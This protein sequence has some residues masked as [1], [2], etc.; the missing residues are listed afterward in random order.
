M[1]TRPRQGW[2]TDKDKWWSSTGII[3]ALDTQRRSPNHGG[4]CE[5]TGNDMSEQKA[6]RSGPKLQQMNE[7]AQDVGL[8]ANYDGD[9]K[10]G[11]TP[12]RPATLQ[13]NTLKLDAKHTKDAEG[14]IKLSGGKEEGIDVHD[15]SLA[16][17]L[18]MENAGEQPRMQ[19]TA[20]TDDIRPISEG[21]ALP[22]HI[23]QTLPLLSLLSAHQRTIIVDHLR[24]MDNDALQRFYKLIN[25][26]EQNGLN[27]VARGNLDKITI[28]ESS[29]MDRVVSLI[30]ALGQASKERDE[31]AMKL[32]P[33]HLNDA[34]PV[35]KQRTH[36]GGRVKR[37]KPSLEEAG[38][39]WKDSNELTHVHEQASQKKTSQSGEN[40]NPKPIREPL[41]KDCSNVVEDYSPGFTKR[42]K[43]SR[44]S[45]NAK[46]GSSSTAVHEPNTIP[47]AKSEMG[48][49][50]TSTQA[51]SVNK[52]SLQSATLCDAKDA[53]LLDRR[54]GKVAADLLKMHDDVKGINELWQR[55][56]LCS[57]TTSSQVQ[58]VATK[59]AASEST[60]SRVQYD[61]T[62][63][64][65][66][67]MNGSAASNEVNSAFRGQVSSLLCDKS[68]PS[69]AKSTNQEY[70]KTP[71]TQSRKEP[72]SHIPVELRMTDEEVVAILNRHEKV[73]EFIQSSSPRAKAFMSTFNYWEDPRFLA[74][75]DDD[76]DRKF[77]NWMA[78]FHP[79]VMNENVLES[80]RKGVEA[81]LKRRRA[82]TVQKREEQPES[83]R[84]T[85]EKAPSIRLEADKK[86]PDLQQKPDHARHLAVKKQ[87]LDA[88][89][90]ADVEAMIEHELVRT[91]NLGRNLEKR[92]AE[93]VK[94]IRASAKEFPE[95][96]R[97]VE[98][99]IQSV[100]ERLNRPGTKT[101]SIGKAATSMTS[102]KYGAIGSSKSRVPEFKSDTLQSMEELTGNPLQF[103]Q[104][105]TVMVRE[106][107]W[108]DPKQ[109][110]AAAGSKTNSELVWKQFEALYE[111]LERRS[112]MLKDDQPKSSNPFPATTPS[113][114]SSTASQAE[115]DIGVSSL[116]G[117]IASVHS[118]FT[119]SDGLTYRQRAALKIMNA[120][121]R[122]QKA[123]ILQLY[124][125]C[126]IL[127][128]PGIFQSLKDVIPELR[129][130][131][132]EYPPLEGNTMVSI[133]VMAT[134][135]LRPP[136]D[137]PPHIVKL[138]SPLKG[139]DVKG[140]PS[141][142]QPTLKSAVKV[143]APARE[144]N[145]HGCAT[146]GFSPSF[147][148][149]PP[150]KAFCHGID[151]S[152]S[153]PDSKDKSSGRPP[154]QSSVAET[155]PHSVAEQLKYT[156]GQ[157]DARK[158]MVEDLS[159]TIPVQ[160]PEPQLDA[161]RAKLQ[162]N[163][164]V[165]AV[166]EEER[167]Q[168]GDLERLGI[169]KWPKKMKKARLRQEKERSR[170]KSGIPYWSFVGTEG[171]PTSS[172]EYQVDR[173]ARDIASA[174][175]E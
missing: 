38:N 111:E 126:E 172:E 44:S 129:M 39:S 30:S 81:T 167:R 26:V 163:P 59:S 150:Q 24:S 107:D 34:V 156:L 54:A 51:T 86:G 95:H 164:E 43:K 166:W 169:L 108:G 113:T 132:K 74:T 53:N 68:E 48:G 36:R 82:D 88:F 168:E 14:L 21:A 145:M 115:L 1:L 73:E 33:K 122:P 133:M 123:R 157:K 85:D 37:A 78:Y 72:T 35:K 13:G 161:L 7:N 77:D 60:D 174:V 148:V 130:A 67:M 154:H 76:F 118:T 75:V 84:S 112:W 110:P 29:A 87:F 102:A 128:D 117:S 103:M 23:T 66:P 45:K 22:D 101:D 158:T 62:A 83:R 94:E 93:M 146:K 120:C 109:D 16:P 136:S 27:D 41:N 152:T 121:V 140:P 116:L 25:E 19:A 31:K 52:T 9:V 134:Y 18:L 63:D 91:L 162:N 96:Q 144:K 137:S 5:L 153:E 17:P 149:P 170:M 125:W 80:I 20:T 6:L 147:E 8:S 119:G 99:K 171:S 89:R 98:S 28:N 114:V 159:L 3:A 90:D 92:A 104:T 106:L 47:H 11:R 131:Q 61:T 127:H 2:V 143:E 71:K 46:H 69:V 57:G 58:S 12:T 138:P 70:P 56:R 97:K 42:D 10:E 64:A 105:C 160:D 151:E 173:Q 175:R 155:P 124:R 49:F 15:S 139:Q 135:N 141:G 4:T 142:M 100:V 79:N 55:I 50:G 40:V 32:T 165:R 65:V